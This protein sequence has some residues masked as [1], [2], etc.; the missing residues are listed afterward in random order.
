MITKIAEDV[1]ENDFFL[2]KILNYDL[3][4]T[5]VYSTGSNWI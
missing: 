4:V 5:E 3:E 1:F 2:M